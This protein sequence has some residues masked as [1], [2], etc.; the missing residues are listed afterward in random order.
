M[1]HTVQY[2]FHVSARIGPLAPPGFSVPFRSSVLAGN[3]NQIFSPQEVANRGLIMLSSGDL[4]FIFADYLCEAAQ[5][6]SRVNSTD[7]K[8]E[9]TLYLRTTF[10]VKFFF[11]L[12]FM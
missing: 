6:D 3:Y 5:P 9:L 4:F 10:K 8:I 7:L 2:L 1:P 11:L 12:C